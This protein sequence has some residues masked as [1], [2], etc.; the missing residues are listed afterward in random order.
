MEVNLESLIKDLATR[1]GSFVKSK[2]NDLSYRQIMKRGS[3]DV[4][5]RIDLEVED[6]IIKGVEKEGL[7]AIISTEERG[8]VKIGDGEPR[9]IFVVDPLDGSLNFVLGIPFYSISIAV[10]RYSNGFRFSDL[11][12]GVVYYVARDAL[13][14]GGPRGIDI[15]GDDLGD[16]GEDIDRP[17]VSIYVEPDANEKLLLGLREIYGR[18]GRF[19]IRSLGSASLEMVMASLG[20]FLAFMDLRSRL[21]IFDIAGAYVIARAMGIGVYTLGGGDLGGE[22]V[23]SDRRFSV[24][25]SRRRDFAGEFL[26][27]IGS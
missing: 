7:N 4:S 15:R 10:G 26:R 16:L 1:A 14:Y 27:L 12:D 18:F 3:T 23:S 17:V 21:R 19:K 11:S 24:I 5:R 25:V 6:I 8:V 22:L 2:S 13:Y 20:R 9:Y